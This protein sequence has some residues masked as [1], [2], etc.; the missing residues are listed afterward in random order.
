MIAGA[1]PLRARLEAWR[2]GLL[3]PGAVEL[4]GHLEDL[5]PFYHGLDVLALPSLSE[6]FGL[7]AAEAG[8]CGVP[9]V[10]AR[11]SSLPE[12]VDDGVSGL[13]TA[14]GDPVALAAALR[15]LLADPGLAARLGAA[16]RARVTVRFDRDRSLDR[17]LELTGVVAPAGG[18]SCPC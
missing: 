13:L 4:A 8:A 5:V 17:L 14:P 9:V 2:A 18:G 6:G 10:A 15:R 7:V 1:G 16:G 11:A 3:C 12:I